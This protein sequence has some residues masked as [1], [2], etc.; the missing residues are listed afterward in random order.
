MQDPALLER[1]LG[2]RLAAVRAARDEVRADAGRLPVV[3]PGL[4]RK[5]GKDA[6]GGGQ[7]RCGD[8]TIDLDAWRQCDLGAALLLL[9]CAPP[10]QALWDLY[11]HGDIEER[12]ML[13][14]A[15]HLLPL[16]QSTVRLLT[17]VQR[18]NMVL[19]VEAACCDGDLVAR[20]AR[21]ALP[22]FGQ[23]EQNRL[24]LKLAFL[25]LPLRRVFGAERLANAELSRMLQDLATER[26]AAGRTVWRD[27]DRL[28]G[29]A[30]VPGTTARIL[31]SLEHGDDGRRLAAAEALAALDR[32]ELLQYA[33]DRLPREPRADVKA[34]LQRIVG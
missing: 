34:L 7:L 26:E 18:T 29:R 30:P 3:F 12:A 15:L 33:R 27:T 6:V 1:K 32:K 16:G 13:L 9:Q 22:G 5:V 2:A 17:E 25:D 23:P 20:A 4:P 24:L 11:E 10:D 8:A 31:G 19:H 28:L 14:R 21:A